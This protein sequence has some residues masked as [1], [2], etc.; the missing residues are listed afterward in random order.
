VLVW[1]ADAVVVVHLAYLA[2]LP[3]GGLL[4][5][6]W[7]RAVWAHLAAVAIGVVSITVGFDCPFTTWE[8]SLRRRGGQRPYTNGFVDHYLTGRVYPHGY[9]W[10]VQL[11]FG[12][13]IVASYVHLARR[14]RASN[15]GPGGS[16][17]SSDRRSVSG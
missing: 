1:L 12:V 10:A 13:C 17:A 16:G 15:C 4:A 7:S 5:W 2:F 9:E 3:L 6:R 8:Q 11:I 14:G